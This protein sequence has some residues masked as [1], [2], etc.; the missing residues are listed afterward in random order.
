MSAADA[1]LELLGDALVDAAAADL[2]RS[3]AVRGGRRASASARGGRRASDGAR[4]GRRRGFTARAKVA[5]ALLAVALAI[6]T[7]A[8]ATGVLDTSEEVAQGLPGGAAMLIG[9][10]PHCAPLRKGIEYECVLSKPPHQW[11]TPA[12]KERAIGEW[13]GEPGE[14]MGAVEA[15]VDPDHHVNG[16]C[17]SRNVD[18]TL[19]SCYLGKEA[20]RQRII[21][22]RF[23]G[24]YLPE[25]LQE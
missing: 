4:G 7:A 20:V 9:T 6:P 22:A 23:L 25:P 8:I 12:G 5:V 2:A 16:G 19:W 13:L 21:G 17:R 15:T 3:E 10:D 24:D 18:G 1:R 11:S 14:W